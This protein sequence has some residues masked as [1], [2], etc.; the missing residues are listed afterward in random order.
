MSSWWQ[1]GQALSTRP[2]FE[3][4]GSI[5]VVAR[6]GFVSTIAWNVPDKN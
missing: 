6:V 2:A 5:E 3:K 4:V 1:L